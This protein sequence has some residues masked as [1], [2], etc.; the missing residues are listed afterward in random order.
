MGDNQVQIQQKGQVKSYDYNQVLA[1]NCTQSEA[2][3][4]CGCAG[5]LQSALDGY[6][7]TIFAYGQTGSGKTYTMAGAE[8]KL[9]TEV[10]VSD[11]TEGI[12]PRAVRYLWQAMVQRQEQFY[13]KASFT[14]IYNEQLRDLLNPSSGILHCRWNVK[15]G[16][17]VEDLMIVE[18]T[19]VDDMIAVLH[20]GMKN[21]KTGAHE[22]NKDSSRSH[23]ILTIYLI[24]ELVNG[25]QTMKRYGKLSFVDLAGSERLKESKSQGDMIK[26]TGN[27]NKSLFTLGK[28]I[29]ALSDK[30]AKQPYVPYRDSKLT[31]LLMDSLGGTAKALMI[32]CISP[33]GAYFEETLS[34]MNYAART[35]NIKNKPVISMDQKDQ[36]I[37]NLQ[38]EIELLKM[39]NQY[40][41]EQLS[42]VSNGLPIEIPSFKN[43]NILPP[44]S[45]NNKNVTSRPMSNQGMEIPINK[46]IQEYQYELNRIKNENEELRNAR[47]HAEKKKV[48]IGN[49]INKGDIAKEK[50][51]Q[52]YMASALMLENSELKKR[53]IELE[54]KNI[55]FQNIIKKNLNGATGSSSA[56]DLYEIMQLKQQNQILQQRVE[57]LQTREKDL[58]ESLIKQQKQQQK[59]DY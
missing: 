14:E 42:R 12:I 20:E 38:K 8:E 4:K 13:V 15:N 57:F 24:S 2:F 17:F 31:M 19:N 11:E 53:I 1:E 50:M 33:S 34:T 22:L 9:C 47:E 10:Y 18:C 46:I 40:L 51:S 27:I 54:N 59:N 21:R 48:F 36:I 26:E 5:L 44:L 37:Y 43:K 55:E 30:K 3:L 6:S 35:M 29:Q 45:Q 56:E 52:D 49:P 23:S 28:V 58:L 25:D 32:A 39:E 41:R 7:A 16:F